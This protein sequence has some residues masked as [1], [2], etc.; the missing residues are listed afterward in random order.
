MCA[1]TRAFPIFFSLEFLKHHGWYC[2]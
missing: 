2:F 1:A